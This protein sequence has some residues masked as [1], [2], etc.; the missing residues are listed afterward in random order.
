MDS[1]K[2]LIGRNIRVKKKEIND[3]DLSYDC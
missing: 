2:F 3:T 1:A